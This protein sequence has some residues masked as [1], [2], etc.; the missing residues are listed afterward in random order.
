MGGEGLEMPWDS[1][2]KAVFYTGILVMALTRSDG[3]RKRAYR[4][5]KRICDTFV[6]F[7]DE[8]SV[9]LSCQSKPPLNMFLFLLL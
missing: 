5:A 7:L 2:K 6:A 3:P 1:R 8:V 9:S 4:P